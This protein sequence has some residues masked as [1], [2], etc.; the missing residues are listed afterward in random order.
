MK[1]HQTIN[2]P[3]VRPPALS[4][5][6]RSILR[7]SWLWLL[8]VAIV[9][10][11]AP[12]AL[13]QG[14]AVTVVNAASYAFDAIA[15]DSLAAAYGS[16]NTTGGQ[17]FVAQTLPLP[18]TLGGV[19]VTVGGVDCGMLAVS[20]AA[21]QIN[22]VM[23]SLANDGATQ[24][25]V[26]NSDGSTRSGSINV[27]RAAAGV[28]TSR[29]SGIGALAGLTTTDG[30]SFQ[31][32][33]H[34]DG[35]EREVS[36]GTR[37][38]PNFLVIFV[39]GLR[40]AP[41]INPNDANGVAESVTATIQGVPATVLY[42]GRGANVGQDQVNLV[43][44]PELA[45]LGLVRLRLSIGGRVSNVT[46]IRIGG[47]APPIRTQTIEA[48]TAV[49]GV[50]TADDQIQASGD[51][52]GRTYFFDA[53]RM[54]ATAANTT[55]ALD[56]RSV[57]FD[58]VVMV[59]RQ[60]TD[61]SLTPVA[62]DD[63]TGG[64]GNGTDENTNALLLAV[65]RDSGDYLVF[66][67]SADGEPN[68]VGQYQLSLRT[69]LLQQISYGTTTSGAA[70]ANTD[71][72]TSAGDFLDAY[73]FAGNAGDFIQIRMASTAF[74]SFVIL[75]ADNG[76][77]VEFDDNSGGGPQGRDSLVTQSLRRNG[78]YIIIATPFEPGRTGA[79]TLTLNRLNSA[80]DGEEFAKAEGRSWAPVRS[81]TETQFD[82]YASR[83]IVSIER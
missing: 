53:Y 72:Q 22:F 40:N 57:H 15:P 48:N 68:A 62:A 38:R 66:V 49:N 59:A 51:G 42:A 78:N 43:I 58:A 41:A 23:P 45:G 26:T 50:L 52:S 67:T 8:S 44:P 64:M 79:Y 16:F 14:V 33:F 74:D 21:G 2:Q 4:P 20:P 47:Q 29:G 71:I 65:L 5:L 39:T 75:N 55:V 32:T 18:T 24:I 77:L 34:A 37:E 73:W 25:V 76:D 17:T 60:A 61:G 12:Q 9:A 80:A 63:Q 35:T 81:L 3:A 31:L 11:N 28:F 13:S 27:Q 6:A 70:I 7:L 46:T 19:R 69:G 30:S 82:R 56:M 36:A 1:Y 54:T 83:R 10:A